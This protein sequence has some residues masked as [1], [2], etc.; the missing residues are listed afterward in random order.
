MPNV[1]RVRRPESAAARSDT[2]VHGR[3]IAVSEQDGASHGSRPSYPAP[4]PPRTP[5]EGRGPIQSY[6][7]V[8]ARGSP[9]RSACASSH[10]VALNREGTRA[11]VLRSHPMARRIDNGWR[12]ALSMSVGARHQGS[13]GRGGRLRPWIRFH[14]GITNCGNSGRKDFL[15]RVFQ[16]QSPS[17]AIRFEMRSDADSSWLAPD[18]IMF[19]S[20][21][22]QMYRVC[23]TRS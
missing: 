17:S 6:P 2:T 20:W 1:T 7:K 10:S 21:K 3:A 11:R 22:L 13:K 9:R 4:S 14:L 12:L 5:A 23:K 15:P 18:L 8:R 16:R 19:S